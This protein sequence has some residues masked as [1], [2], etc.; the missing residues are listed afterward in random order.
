[1]STCACVHVCM[2]ACVHVAVYS[3]KW[4]RWRTFKHCGTMTTFY[5]MTYPCE[6]CK[7]IVCVCVCV[8]WCVFGVLVCDV[9]CIE[10]TPTT[11]TV[12]CDTP[13]AVC[14]YCTTVT[15]VYCSLMRFM[16]PAPTPTPIYGGTQLTPGD[17]TSDL[18][19]CYRSQWKMIA[20]P[21]KQINM[22]KYNIYIITVTG[23][24][25]SCVL[26]LHA[27][28]SPQCHAT[29]S[30]LNNLWPCSFQ[31]DHSVYCNC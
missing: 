15:V 7:V 1:M 2:C 31:T 27:Q 29:P 28:H 21:F 12:W 5:Y 10:V 11:I 20:C 16:K 23:L 3:G 17:L 26:Q 22:H 18:Q 9:G 13:Q 6:A 30:H 14:I 19:R 25:W 24:S 4:R 8:R